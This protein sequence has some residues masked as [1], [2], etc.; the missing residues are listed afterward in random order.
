MLPKTNLL[1]NMYIVVTHDPGEC[2][3]P[4]YWV[5]N[6][7]SGNLVGEIRKQA[8]AEPMLNHG[9]I[10]RRIFR[11]D[12]NSRENFW[13]LC[14]AIIGY[15]ISLQNFT[16]ATTEQLSCRAQNFTVITFIENPTIAEWNFHQTCINMDELFG[17][18]W[19]Q[20]LCRHTAPL[21]YN[22]AWC[23]WWHRMAT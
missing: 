18:K 1:N 23:Q 9:P 8:I 7:C 11:R 3:N 6:S 21:C 12:S 5:V 15:H 17:V 16:H 4:H 13:F 14:N 2:Q 19:A 20:D 10:S 22:V